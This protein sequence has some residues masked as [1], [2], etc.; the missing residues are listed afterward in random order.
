MK[1][2]QGTTGKAW[3]GESGTWTRQSNLGSS[4]S[5]AFALQSHD[6]LGL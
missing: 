2:G 1:S 5:E 3:T 6:F 4:P